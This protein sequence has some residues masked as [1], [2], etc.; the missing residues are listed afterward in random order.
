MRVFEQAEY[1]LDQ[2]GTNENSNE[3]TVE[4][5]VRDTWNIYPIPYP[6][7]DSNSGFR[8]GMKFYYFNALGTLTDFTLFSNMDIS[9]SDEKGEWEIPDWTIYP[10]L[11][12]INIWGQDFSLQLGQYYSTTQ[13]Y[14]SGELQQE[15]SLHNT[16]M[17]LGTTLYMP[18][19][20]YYS[21]SPTVAFSYGLSELEK[22]KN[23][24]TL[25]EYG[26]EIDY[27]PVSFSWNHSIG[28]SGIDWIGNFREGFSVS[29]SNSLAVGSVV[30]STDTLGFSAGFGLGG[31]AFWIINKHLNLST[32]VSTILS[33]KEQTGL[34]DNLRGVIDDYMYGYMGAFASIDLNISVIDWDGVGEIQVRPFFEMGIVDKEDEAFDLDN[35][36]AYTTGADFVLYL[37]KMNSMQ[38][39]ATLGMDLSNYAWSDWDKYEITITSALSY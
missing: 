12:G 11:S 17:S 14:D 3:Y 39:R 24:D 29:L 32:K 38:A 18:Y 26:E 13:K 21:M 23:G 2:T 36:F 19:D 28:Y 34:G 20:F 7:Y 27:S 35:D 22:D 1:T 25:P 4:L 8:L 9:Y 31:K 5:T 33:S 16:S 30:D 10:G 6:K 37:D 15:Y